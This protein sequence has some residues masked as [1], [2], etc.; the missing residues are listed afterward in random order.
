MVKRTSMA[1]FVDA[2]ITMSR[3]EP[4]A[5]GTSYYLLPSQ[6]GCQTSWHQDFSATS[7]L[8]TVLTG[9]K[10]FFLIAPTE[11]NLKLFYDWFQQQ[12]DET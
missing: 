7:V 10:I 9:E 12:T 5:S 2:S 6:D 8:Y 3:T 11:K 1:H 4:F